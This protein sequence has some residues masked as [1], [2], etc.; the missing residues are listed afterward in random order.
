[1]RK[2]KAFSTGQRIVTEASSDGMF[3]RTPS[4]TTMIRMAATQLDRSVRS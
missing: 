4:G 2:S 1:V 3:Q